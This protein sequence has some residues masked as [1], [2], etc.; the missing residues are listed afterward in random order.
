MSRNLHI[1]GRPV[2]VKI[3]PDAEAWKGYLAGETPE[4][5]DV[6]IVS[7]LRE[8]LVEVPRDKIILFDRLHD[9]RSMIRSFKDVKTLVTVKPKIPDG[10]YAHM[11]YLRRKSSLEAAAA[12]AV[13]PASGADA[14]AMVETDAEDETG[15][16]D[17]TGAEG[18]AS[19]VAEADADTENVTGAEEDAGLVNQSNVGV[20][21]EVSQ[22]LKKARVCPVREPDTL[23]I[24]H[25]SQLEDGEVDDNQY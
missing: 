18:E 5:F 4:G 2:L 15:A 19:P 25:E 16:E 20:D 3:H 11:L 1:P 8:F 23:P 21:A 6:E 7:P 24:L 9:E 17:N 10:N 14:D 22:P 12:A 13:G